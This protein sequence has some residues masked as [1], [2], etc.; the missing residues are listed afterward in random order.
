MKRTWIKVRCGILT[1]E[2]VGAIGPAIWLFLY[3]LDRVDWQTGQLE[4]W[5]DALASDD[6]G[7]P[8][9]TVRKHRG[10]LEEEGYIR[11]RAGYQ[12]LAIEVMNYSGPRT[13][14]NK[15]QSD[16]DAMGPWHG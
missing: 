6:M 8:K 11:C 1:P 13:A 10:R 5:R 16:D 15:H 3:I 14:T 9:S 2:H 12:S 4:D 7:I